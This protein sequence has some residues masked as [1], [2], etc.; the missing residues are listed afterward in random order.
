MDLSVGNQS[1]QKADFPGI[2]RV[3]FNR[4]LNAVVV[5]LHQNGHK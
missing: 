4:V 2:L 3:H 1:S 5:N